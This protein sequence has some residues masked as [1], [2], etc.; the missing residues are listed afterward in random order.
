MYPFD[1]RLLEPMI[2]VLINDVS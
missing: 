2:L 1:V